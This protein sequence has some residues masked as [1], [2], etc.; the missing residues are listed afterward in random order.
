MPRRTIPFDKMRIVLL[1]N[2]YTCLQFLSARN[3]SGKVTLADLPPVLVKLKAVVDL[4][5][6]NEIRDI[7]RESHPDLDQEVDFE[8]FLRV[9]LYI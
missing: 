6:E 2:I 4:L 7:L 9:C 1:T 8:A 5:T 3:Q